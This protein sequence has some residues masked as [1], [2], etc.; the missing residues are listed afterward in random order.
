MSLSSKIPMAESQ[1]TQSAVPTRVASR[2]WRI[3][4][5]DEQL[6]TSPSIQGTIWFLERGPQGSAAQPPRKTQAEREMLT[7]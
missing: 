2:K 1:S 5:E 6:T 7:V 3:M 4:G